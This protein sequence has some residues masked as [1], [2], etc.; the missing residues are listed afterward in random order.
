MFSQRC[1]TQTD[2]DNGL[3]FGPRYAPIVLLVLFTQE[4][5][6]FR[7]GSE[8]G[9]NKTRSADELFDWGRWGVTGSEVTHG[10]TGCGESFERRCWGPH[11]IYGKV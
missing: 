7:G 1:G 3:C 9:G 6:E 10:E 11:G 8:K 4:V 2:P 5:V